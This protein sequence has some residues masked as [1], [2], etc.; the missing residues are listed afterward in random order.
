MTEPPFERVYAGAFEEVALETTLVTAF[1]RGRRAELDGRQPHV[2]FLA[3]VDGAT[4]G[5]EGL[6]LPADGDVEVV[7]VDNASEA[8]V[9]CLQFAD[10]APNRTVYRLPQRLPRAEAWAVAD[11]LARGATTNDAVPRTRELAVAVEGA[12]LAA[13][14]SLLLRWREAFGPAAPA[15]LVVVL[16]PAAVEELVRSVEALEADGGEV[17]DLVAVVAHD[18][19]AELARIAPL[20]RATLSPSVTGAPYVR[21]DRLAAL[22]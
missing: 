6:G 13:D 3:V 12:D 2:S 17:G 14:P 10:A 16:K 4:L 11:A 20:C 7:L 1:P 22:A 19:R 21:P 8:F 18:V 15:S 5:L 9:P